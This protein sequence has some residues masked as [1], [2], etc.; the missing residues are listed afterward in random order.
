MTLL[1]EL[2]RRLAEE[3]EARLGSAGLGVRAPRR[4]GALRRALTK[5]A[6]KAT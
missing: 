3:A 2:S 5:R 4:I 1:E 6:Q